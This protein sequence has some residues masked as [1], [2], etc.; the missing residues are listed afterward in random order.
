M[1]GLAAGGTASGSPAAA[2][3]TPAAGDAAAAAALA[4]EVRPAPVD[5]SDQ[6]KGRGG[7]PTAKPAGAPSTDKVTIPPPSPAAPPPPPG[8]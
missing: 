8:R 6:K 4:S 7:L 2:G 1:Q 3:A 5:A